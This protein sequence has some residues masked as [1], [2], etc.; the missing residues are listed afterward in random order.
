[1]PISIFSS[2]VLPPELAGD[3]PEPVAHAAK[4]ME[5]SAI[6]VPM[7]ASLVR[8]ARPLI[9]STSPLKCPALVAGFSPASNEI[10]LMSSK[11]SKVMLL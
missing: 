7:A 1:M 11:R 5:I 8:L 2:G 3:A 9:V 4:L 10:C 6:P